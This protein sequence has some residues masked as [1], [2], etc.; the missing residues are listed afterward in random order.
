MNERSVRTAA[1]RAGRFFVTLAAVSTV[2]SS[3]PGVITEARAQTPAVQRDVPYGSATGVDLLMDVYTPS[4]DGPFPAVIV[5][6]GGGLEAGGKEQMQNIAT[7][8]A[9]NGYMAFAIDYRLAPEFVFPAALEDCLQAVRDVREHAADRNV[10]P[11]RIG[12]LGTSAGATM[13]ALVGGVGEASTR[14]S[15][16]VSW[17]GPMDLEALLQQIPLKVE[18]LLDTVF[19]PDATTEDLAQASPVN[20]VTPKYPPTFIANSSPELIPFAQAQAMAT[21]LQES[22]VPHVLWTAPGGHALA[23]QAFVIGPSIQFLDGSLMN[24]STSSTAPTSPPTTKGEGWHFGRRAK[25]GIAG[26]AI[27]IVAGVVVAITRRRDRAPDPPAPP[28]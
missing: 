4:G 16:V 23:Y 6:H 21:K 19:G 5:I 24:A 13:A 15:A 8:L 18:A 1:A 17:S 14:V 3:A 11:D 7:Q 22:G 10:D 9:L 27:L 12:V 20:R 26:L 25:A 2:M 28:R